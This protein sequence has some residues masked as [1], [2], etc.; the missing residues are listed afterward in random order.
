VTRIGF[1]GAGKVGFSLGR[2]MAERG[3]SLTGYASRTL[4][5]AE[6]AAAFTGS[7]AYREP[8]ALLEDSD[9]V[10]L[11]VP[12]DAVAAVWKPLSGGGRA[13]G[14]VLCH[15]S[16]FLSSEAFAGLAEAG[17]FGASL[18]PLMAVPDREGS[19]RLLADALYAVEG[20]PE[21]LDRLAPVCA[22]LG[23]AAG[24]VG[25]ADKAL[26]HCAAALVSNCAVALAFMG[27]GLFRSIGLADSVPG[28]L[29]LMLRNAQ[30][31]AERGPAGALTGP[32]ERGDAGTVRAH[33]A[34]LAGH[35]RE[36]YRRLCL[37]LVELSRLKHPERDFGP[38]AEALEPFAPDSAGG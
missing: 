21:A 34:A 32:V 28:L 18:H 36:L 16:G 13:R 35:D 33:L 4:A 8:E 9:I 24:V 3:V 14:K 19:W 37:K 20:D 1:I 25:K 22:A 17:G 6:G 31:V 30:S 29:S 23:I 11:T 26:Y 2:L 12:D 5:S 10:F 7:R 38:L 15:T 27:E